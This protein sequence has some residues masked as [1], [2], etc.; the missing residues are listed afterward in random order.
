MYRSTALLSTAL[1]LVTLAGCSGFDEDNAAIQIR[2]TFCQG[3][4]YGCTENTVVEIGKVRET[5]HGRQVEFKVVDGDDETATLQSAYFEREDD[6]WRLLFFE[7]PFS[8]Q[9]TREENRAI[10]DRHKL[11]KQL[12][13]LKAAQKWFTTIYRRY[14]SNLAELDSVSYHPP[15]PALKMTVEQGGSGWRGEVESQYTRCVLEVPRQQLPSCEGLSAA[16]G[17]GTSSGPLSTAFG[18]GS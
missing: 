14:A 13:D 5:L 16:Q 4:P 3:W 7:P 6:E 11:E 17:A 10:D 18:E 12:M 2:E 8:K 15:G 9:F 1:G